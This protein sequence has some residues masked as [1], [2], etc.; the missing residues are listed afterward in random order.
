MKQYVVSYAYAGSTKVSL[1]EDGK[2]LFANVIADYALESYLR[3]LEDD[4]HT[5][6]FDVQKAQE[7]LDVARE[8]YTRALEALEAAKA[9]P[10]ILADSK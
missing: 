2:F 10:L 4:G 3:F 8:A 5:R 7:E 1:Y 9:S 6:A